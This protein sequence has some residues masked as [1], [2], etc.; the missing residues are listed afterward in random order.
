MSSS[1]SD[2]ISYINYISNQVGRYASIF[3]FIFGVTGNILNIF[4]LSRRCFRKNS[5]AILFLVSSVANLIAILS[6][7]TSRMSSNWT[8]DPTNNDRSLCKLRAFILNIARTVALWLITL[9]AID[10]WL[11]SST[12]ARLRRKSTL[13]NAQRG[14]IVVIIISTILYSHVLYCYEPN[15]INAPSQCYGTTLTCRYVTDTCFTFVTVLIPILLMFIVSLMTIQ[16][17]RQSRRRIQPGNAPNTI[18]IWQANANIGRHRSK[19]ETRLLFML[20]SQV[21]LLFVF[22]LPLGVQKLYATFT[23]NNSLSD[24]QNAVTNIVYSIVQL[25][26]FSTN[27]LP[28]YIYTIAG[29]NSFRKEFKKM[30]LEIKQKVHCHC[31]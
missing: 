25:L 13:K 31:R 14:I 23:A 30:F 3:I 21:I 24:L 18:T 12:N 5:C 1:N 22:G 19:I 4:V 29:G 28:F 15:L 2:Y 17:I 16:N 26:N 9:A 27:G 8:I 20:L 10:R 11:L 7:L 6:G